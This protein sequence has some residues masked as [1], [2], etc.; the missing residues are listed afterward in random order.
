[1]ADIKVI[2]NSQLVPNRMLPAGEIHTQVVTNDEG[3][4]LLIYGDRQIDGVS[5]PHDH[6]ENGGQRLKRH[7]LSVM[8][9]PQGPE[10]L[11]VSPKQGILI[12]LSD[13]S[14]FR[15]SLAASKLLVSSPLFL[16]GGI[17]SCSVT[18]YLNVG[19]VEQEFLLHVIIRSLSSVGYQAGEGL[20]E[21]RQSF[22]T[23]PAVGNQFFTVTF[24]DLADFGDSGS[25]RDV[26]I[27][28]FQQFHATVEHR[29][30]GFSVDDTTATANERVRAGRSS[31]VPRA[32]VQTADVLSGH[33][34]LSTE[35]ASRIR[36]STN[37]RSLALYG[38]APGLKDLN[39]T[40]DRRNGWVREICGVHQHQGIKNPGDGGTIEPDG[41]VIRQ[42]YVNHSF[43]RSLGEN[44]P[45]SAIQ[46]NG[47]RYLGLKLHAAGVINIGG[48][49][50][51]LESRHLTA[52]PAGL[53]SL[54]IRFAML[55]ATS[56]ILTECR[57]HIT[58]H[59]PSTS[60]VPDSIVTSLD[61]PGH[62]DEGV[63]TFLEEGNAVL[64]TRSI[65]VDPIQ[66]PGFQSFSRRKL[67]GLGLWTRNALLQDTVRPGNLPKDNVYLVS[68]PV[69]A[70]LTQPAV[71]AAE[72]R[73]DT[74]LYEIRVR[75]Q[76]KTINSGNFDEDARLNWIM[77]T[78]GRGW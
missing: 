35:L 21:R 29:L 40:V 28:I 34:V 30:L 13:G 2:P 4:R 48:L 8:L 50:Q 53:G 72:I 17:E 64:R 37:Q 54:E 31:D 70:R 12:G 3:E 24:S 63:T 9:G 73:H 76:L 69:I 60:L 15:A 67:L 36:K 18:V 55:P 56:D 71:N 32:K 20:V 43:V 62:A 47:N 52:I 38:A 16:R 6:G 51:W 77:V 14:D 23:P 58:V 41:A 42:P 59:K 57:L 22:S 1:M 33:G 65:Q 10:D 75:I 49:N 46:V 66:H 26:E 78:P 74:T 27:C 11:S 39:R 45:T 7:L 5:P 25:D 61:T 19:V 68:K 44:T